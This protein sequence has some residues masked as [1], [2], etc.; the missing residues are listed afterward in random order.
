MESGET[1]VVGSGR[2]LKDSA[3]QGTHKETTV[4][5]VRRQTQQ[6]EQQR[7]VVEMDGSL[8]VCEA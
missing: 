4:R 1:L 3:V 8:E 7:S 5:T 6:S 2:R